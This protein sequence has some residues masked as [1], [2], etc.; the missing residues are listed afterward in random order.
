V[1]PIDAATRHFDADAA[2]YD[3][4]RRRLVPPFDASASRLSRPR[5]TLIA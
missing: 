2:R 1:E 4:E 5:A 3:A